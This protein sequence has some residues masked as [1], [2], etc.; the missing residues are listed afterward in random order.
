MIPVL[1][2]AMWGWT[3][4]RSRAFDLADRFYELNGRWFDTAC[5][6]PINRDPARFGLAARWL[7]DWCTARHPIDGCVVGKVGALRNDGS[8]LCDLGPENLL[9]QFASIRDLFGPCLRVFSIH[10]DNRSDQAAVNET[11]D[12]LRSVLRD[13][14]DVGLSGIKHPTLYWNAL[15]D[16]AERCWIQVK[17][18]VLSRSAYSHYAPFHGRSK[19]LAYGLNAGG[20]KLGATYDDAS[21][22]R[23][24]G[25]LTSVDLSAFESILESWR[26]DPLLPRTFN[27]LAL[28]LVGLENRF[29]GVLIGPSRIDQLEESMFFLPRLDSIAADQRASAQLARA[30]AQ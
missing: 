1:G 15:E 23:V 18:N 13:G 4:D 29:A 17:L 11:S 9:R 19:F 8:D 21:S 30:L 6:Y 7:A 20:L 26:K 12:V 27:E 2:T 22:A 5:N 25:A 28:A 16:V 3:V 14:Y 24:R 10:W